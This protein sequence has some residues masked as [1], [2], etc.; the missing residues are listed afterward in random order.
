MEKIYGNQVMETRA[1]SLRAC[2]AAILRYPKVQ[3]CTIEKLRTSDLY[4]LAS[5]ALL[6]VELY[7]P[8]SEYCVGTHHGNKFKYL[9]D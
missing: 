5:I 1:R 3:Y 4:I 6:R 8:V 7:C 2:Y 9:D